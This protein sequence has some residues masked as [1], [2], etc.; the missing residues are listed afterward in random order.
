ML[1]PAV[2]R[3]RV[4]REGFGLAAAAAMAAAA[5]A[6]AA[7]TAACEPASS[8]AAGFDPEALERGAKALREINKSPNAKQ[9]CVKGEGG[10]LFS[11][12]CA[13]LADAG[14]DASL[15]VVAKRAGPDL[16]PDEHAL[17]CGREAVSSA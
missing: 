15:A 6:A 2:A 10:A 16:R 9:V 8:S 17:L 5:A 11:L 1:R 14:A 3:W 4:T 13:P 12:V 7:P